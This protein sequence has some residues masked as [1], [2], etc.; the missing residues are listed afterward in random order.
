MDMLKKAYTKNWT[1]L[2]CVE[3][4]GAHDPSKEVCYILDK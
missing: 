1:H 2:K 3:A 4:G